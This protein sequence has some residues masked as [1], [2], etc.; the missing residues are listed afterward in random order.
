MK[1][2]TNRYELKYVIDKPTYLRIR[3]E[4]RLLFK[5]DKSAGKIGKYDVISIYYDTPALDFFGKR[6]MVKK[7]A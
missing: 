7:N 5:L 2:F 4:I 1:A 3:K 6:S